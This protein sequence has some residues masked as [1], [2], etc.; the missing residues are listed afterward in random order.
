MTKEDEPFVPVNAGRLARMRRAVALA[1]EGSFAEAV[2]LLTPEV[3]DDFG[4]VEHDLRLF[5][6][7]LKIAIEQT[8]AAI[9]E[10]R[11]SKRE[12][13]VQLT[14]VERQ[15][16]AIRE[17][18][19]PIIDVWDGILTIPLVGMIDSARMVEL[20]ERLLARIAQASIAWVIFDLTGIDVVDIEIA[21]H[22]SKLAEAVRLMGTGCLLAGIRPRVAQTFVSL[23]TPLGDL[24]VV[25]S[26]RDGLRFCLAQGR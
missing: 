19:A 24:R 15:R 1:S 12:L 13:Q 17:L 8:D 9:E 16:I 10:L 2:D 23:D 4:A 14:T 3:E 18:S 26:L 6:H 20:T 21:N 22:L 11:S 25:G 5:I 7:E